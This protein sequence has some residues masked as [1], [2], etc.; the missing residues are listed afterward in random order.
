M[1]ATFDYD[2]DAVQDSLIEGRRECGEC[3]MW[4][5]EDRMDA[6]TDRHGTWY[7]CRRCGERDRAEY[8]RHVIDGGRHD[9]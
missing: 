6:F 1:T 5:D 8:D 4:F 7:R 9:A 3:G 2:H